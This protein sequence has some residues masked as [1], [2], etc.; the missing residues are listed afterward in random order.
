MSSS[1]R[2]PD[3]VNTAALDVYYVANPAKA[4]NRSPD[5]VCIDCG[6]QKNVKLPTWL[7]DHLRVYALFHPLFLRAHLCFSWFTFVFFVATPRLA[8]TTA[9]A[10]DT[11]AMPQEPDARNMYGP[12]C[13]SCLSFL[14][15]R[16]ILLKLRL[17]DLASL[18]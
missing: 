2:I 1:R 8:A 18:Q 10:S 14:L 16:L 3:L 17:H 6:H 11:D 12:R 9:A 13:F 7:P 4:V 5:R 15:L